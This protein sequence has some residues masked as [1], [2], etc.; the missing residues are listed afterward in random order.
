[1]GVLEEY[2]KDISAYRLGWLVF[3]YYKKRLEVKNVSGG[4]RQAKKSRV[5]DSFKEKM[6]EIRN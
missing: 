4:N 1:M 5:N 2:Y 3:N 6:D